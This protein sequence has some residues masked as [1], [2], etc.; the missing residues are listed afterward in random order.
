MQAT[1]VELQNKLASETAR[2]ESEEKAKKHWM[3]EKEAQNAVHAEQMQVK[4]DAA[5]K[6]ERQLKAEIEELRRLLEKEAENHRVKVL[7]MD[8]QIA[9]LRKW[10]DEATEKNTTLTKEKNHCEEELSE[11]EKRLLAK[12]KAEA[13]LRERK[14]PRLENEISKL[15]VVIGKKEAELA[16]MQKEVQSKSLTIEQQQKTIEGYEAQLAELRMQVEVLNDEKMEAQKAFK[17]L[18]FDYKF[19]KDRNAALQKEIDELKRTLEV[20]DRALAALEKKEAELQQ[21]YME[22]KQEHSKCKQRQQ[23]GIGMKLHDD[24]DDDGNHVVRM[25]QSVL[26]GAVFLEQVNNPH[27]RLKEGDIILE[28]D[29]QPVTQATGI[30][31]RVRGLEGTTVQIRVKPQHDDPSHSYPY[32]GNDAIDPTRDALAMPCVAGGAVQPVP[33]CFTPYTSHL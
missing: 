8:S 13:D 1:V 23:C 14:V 21:S 29:G 17:Q 16:A 6:M 7:P 32:T 19:L 10:L 4:T 20:A 3:A 24:E 31:E 9:E 28:I 12:T 2:A 33:F 27:F 22:L 15:D 26:G 11:M 5:Q 30:A 18:E 25:K